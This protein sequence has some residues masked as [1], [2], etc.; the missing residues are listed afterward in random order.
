[1]AHQ[2]LLEKMEAEGRRYQTD[3]HPSHYSLHLEDGTLEV[4]PLMMEFLTLTAQY[5]AKYGDEFLQE[6]IAKQQRTNSSNLQFLQEQH[7]RHG[8]FLGLVESY[9]RILNASDAETE[10]RL[11]DQFG[12]IA[13]VKGVV[14]DKM[15]YAKASLARRQAALLTDEALRARLQ[16][17]YFQVL[18][19]FSLS[20]VM[21][22]GP[23]PPTAMSQQ[24]QQQQQQRRATTTTTATT[25]SYWKAEEVDGEGDDGD[26]TEGKSSTAAPSAKR[27]RIDD[28]TDADPTAAPV[29]RSSEVGGPTPPTFQPTFMSSNLVRAS[30]A[31]TTNAGGGA[32]R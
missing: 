23:V 29:V 10:E 16:W 21:L 18:H 25:A 24:Q 22:D 27:W 13:F 28:G 17:S 26:E 31:T 19:T 8:V 3:P 6:L 32:G 15:K 1:M 2:E 14:E 9:R 5:V 30:N 7:P 20:D 11:V 12:S 4:P